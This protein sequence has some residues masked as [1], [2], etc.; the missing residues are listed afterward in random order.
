MLDGVCMRG[1]VAI[2]P[3]VRDGFACLFCAS[4]NSSVCDCKAKEA[5][6]EFCVFATRAFEERCRRVF[7]AT[8]ESPLSVICRG[9]IADR[10][11]RSREDYYARER[12]GSTDHPPCPPP[13][14]GHLRTSFR[15]AAA[16]CSSGCR[17]VAS[18]FNKIR[19]LLLG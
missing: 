14:S 16:G 12:T 19:D 18:P 2:R 4:S 13:R 15:S 7:A 6:T 5:L 10:R 11:R 3:V 17:H 1:A 8:A 9:K